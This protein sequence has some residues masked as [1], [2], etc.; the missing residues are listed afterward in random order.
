MKSKG[1]ESVNLL[2]PQTCP[3]FLIICNTFAV[4]FKPDALGF[5]IK[6][7]APGAYSF[8]SRLFG[9]L[10]GNAGLSRSTAEFALATPIVA[11]KDLYGLSRLESP[12]DSMPL[13]PQSSN[14]NV[15]GIKIFLDFD[16]GYLAD[17]P[18]VVGLSGSTGFSH[19]AFRA[20]GSGSRVE[21][22]QEIVAAVGKD[23]AD[24]SVDVLWD[25]HWQNNPRLGK[26]DSVILVGGQGAWLTGTNPIIS[27]SS[28]RWVAGAVPRDS[29]NTATNVGFAF[30]TATAQAFDRIGRTSADFIQFVANSISHELGHTFGLDHVTQLAGT[31]EA[32]G[33]VE[34]GTQLSGD[35]AFSDVVL[36]RQHGSPISSRAHLRHIFATPT[37]SA[38]TNSE[39]GNF[40]MDEVLLTLMAPLDASRSVIPN[41][42]RD[43]SPIR[44]SSPAITSDYTNAVDTVFATTSDSWHPERQ[45]T[46][47]RIANKDQF[48]GLK[49]NPSSRILPEVLDDIFDK[50]F[51]R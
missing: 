8:D 15:N 5:A 36:P 6:V 14:P 27:S 40:E 26:G 38:E 34:T 43:Q 35:G 44:D 45:P 28:V 2:P 49:V 48:G 39:S 42:L 16:G 18:E 24:F 29:G 32:M 33:T 12:F 47:I 20:Y 10:S 11:D 1:E 3:G 23:F 25:D 22:I 30:S 21:Q 50:I 31:Q 37:M 7:V 13:A 51:S 46:Q 9:V 19:E 41:S 17:R 4:V